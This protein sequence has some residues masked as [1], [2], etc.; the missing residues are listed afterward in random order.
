MECKKEP[1]IEVKEVCYCPAGYHG[2]RCNESKDL[3][4]KIDILKPNMKAGCNGTDSND[5]VYSIKG[6]EAC[7]E[8]DLDKDFEIEFN[9]TC[10]GVDDNEQVVLGG[11][12]EGIGYKYSDVVEVDN[13]TLKPFAYSTRNKWTNTT[14]FGEFDLD[15]SFD[16]RDF[17]YLSHM[18]RFSQKITDPDLAAGLK[19]GKLTINLQGIK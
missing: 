18:K 14:I 8:I 1:R 4:C 10:R 9:I 17:K 16:V 5:F 7:H 12:Q 15:F 6:Y 3:K 13:S 11:H 2:W 19:T